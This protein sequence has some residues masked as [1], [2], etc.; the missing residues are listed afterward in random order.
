MSSISLTQIGCN[1][2][3]SKRANETVFF[4]HRGQGCFAWNTNDELKGDMKNWR[5]LRREGKLTIMPENSETHTL[6]GKEVYILVLTE[7][8]RL[9]WDPLGHCFDDPILVDGL[10]YAFTIKEN[11][12]RVQAYVMET[13]GCGHTHCDSD[14]LFKR[15]L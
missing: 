6:D 13:N 8:G 14:S 2:F 3:N 15:N 7:E 9:G 4:A 12:D 10:I 1:A 5:K 11:R